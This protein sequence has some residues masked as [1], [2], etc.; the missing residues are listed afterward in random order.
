M[1][2]HVVVECNSCDDVFE[3][4]LQECEDYVAEHFDQELVIQPK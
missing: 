3:G 4:T 2:I 1:K